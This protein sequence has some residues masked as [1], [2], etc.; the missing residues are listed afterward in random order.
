MNLLRKHN[1]HVR[2]H[3]KGSSEICNQKLKDQST[4]FMLFFK[5]CSVAL[6]QEW[7]RPNMILT[8]VLIFVIKVIMEGER[9]RN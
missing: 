2:Q 9:E 6:I 1:R 3:I 7:P 4:Y 8:R 5:P